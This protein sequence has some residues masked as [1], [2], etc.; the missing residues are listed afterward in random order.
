MT[1]TAPIFQLFGR[2][3]IRPMQEH[4]KI[5]L[6]CSSLLPDFFSAIHEGNWTEAESLQQ[7]IVTLENDA[8][9][10]KLDIRQHLPS[11][12]FLPAP[13]VDLLRVVTLQDKIA[14]KAKDIAGLMLGRKM[15]FPNA[16]LASYNQLVERCLDTIKQGCKA[17][18][19]LD[20]LLETGF[21][22]QEAAFV[23]DLLQN[24]DDF[25]RDTDTIQVEVRQQMFAI[26][27]E[28]HPIDMMFLYKIVD[29]T[30]DLADRAQK[31]GGQLQV[32]LAR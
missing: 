5:V 9:K 30:G 12:F 7:R 23:E 32:I 21:R 18:N 26:E 27:K 3:P 4:M 19:E 29:W 13:R 10:L 8:D 14:N 20:S 25:E 2:S 16:V 22:G 28:H 31:L 17:I 6:E 15:Q 11:G 1:P 24:L